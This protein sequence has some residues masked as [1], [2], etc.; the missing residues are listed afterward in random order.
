MDANEYILETNR[1]FFDYYFNLVKD[2]SI[3]YAKTS[4]HYIYCTVKDILDGYEVKLDS[5]QI[6]EIC[7]YVWEQIKLTTI[8]DNIL[9]YVKEKI[10]LK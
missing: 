8:D 2:E 9:N 4:I 1:R 10:D 5:D 3:D 6:E 7:F